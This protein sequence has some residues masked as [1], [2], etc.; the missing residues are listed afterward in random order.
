MIKEQI[1]EKEKLSRSE[2]L[3]EV[4]K[5]L[6]RAALI[7]HHFA[8]TLVQELGQKKGMELIHKAV[9]AYGKQVGTEAREKALAKGFAL[10]PE[11]FESDL[12][13]IAWETEE[14][15]VEGEQRSRVSHCPLAAEWLAWGDRKTARLYCHVDQAKMRAFNPSLEYLHIRNILDGDPYCELAIRRISKEEPAAE[16]N[17]AVAHAGE[18]VWWIGGRYTRDDLMKMDPACLRAL[19]RERVH[20]S[21]EVNLY[22]I[23]LGKKKPPKNYGREPELILSIW[24]Q[25][26]LSQ[27]GEDIEWGKKYIALAKDVREGK[28]VRKPKSTVRPFAPKE[29]QTVEKLIWDRHSIRDWIPGRRIP[30]ALIAKILEAGRAA[31]TACNLS[32]ARFIVI[33]DQAEMKMVWSDI[34]TPAESCVMIVICY[35]KRI[36][37]TVGHDRIVGHN[38]LLDCAAAGDHMCLMA[39]A[40]GLGA[41]WLT[42]TDETA[43]RFRMKYGLPEYIRPLMHVAVGWPAA[44]T[45]KSGRVPL[46]EM[47]IKRGASD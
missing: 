29:M 9:E 33:R 15:T 20:H 42:A 40:L 19:F 31:P 34:P 4:N 21:I 12:P 45:I 3:T 46:H 18:T 17:E 25:R 32:A 26:G 43:E 39:H 37:Q 6:R 38:Q 35:D 27:E 13:D 16:K 11:H 8:E 7:Y 24:R 44:G 1:L 14:V 23:L 47:V 22:P 28:K 36:F 5:A 10:T 41:V 2:A 30:D